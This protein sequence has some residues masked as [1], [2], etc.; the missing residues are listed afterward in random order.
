MRVRRLS[1]GTTAMQ[2]PIIH[3]MRQLRVLEFD[4]D[5]HRRIVNPH[6]LLRNRESGETLLRA[7]QTGGTSSSGKPPCWRTFLLDRIVGLSVRD[8]TFPGAGGLRSR[9]LPASH[10]SPLARRYGQKMNDEV[11]GCSHTSGTARE[12]VAGR[13]AVQRTGTASESR[14]RSRYLEILQS[15]RPCPRLFS[16]SFSTRPITSLR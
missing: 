6:A 10:S 11:H 13:A 15:S 1:L 12:R 5:D 4:Y 8:E 14:R 7:W 9:S 3:A 16:R 2:E